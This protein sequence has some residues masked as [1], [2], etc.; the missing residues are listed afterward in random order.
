[1]CDGFERIVSTEVMQ[2]LTPG[3]QVCGEVAAGSKSAR[4]RWHFS[5][6]PTYRSRSG[7]ELARVFHGNRM[8][9]DVVV[10]ELRKIY[11]AQAVRPDFRGSIRLTDGDI[12]RWAD[13]L[14]TCRP[15]VYDELAICLARGFH[16]SELTFEFCD[17]VMNG[18][19]D[20]IANADERRPELFWRVYVAFDEGEYHH[21]NNRQD[22]PIEAYTRPLIA[23]IL[24]SVSDDPS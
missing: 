11:Q 16:A 21:D 17:A 12:Q 24:S 20:R 2:P 3:K 13:L 18:I 14:G 23:Q 6:M 22:D 19:H 10:S 5:G 4:Q 15:Q 9:A 7:L 8:A 1:V